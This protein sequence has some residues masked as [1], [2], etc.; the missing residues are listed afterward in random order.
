M[1]TD[2]PASDDVP[3]LVTHL[4]PRN[5]GVTI[6]LGETAAR[7]INALHRSRVEVLL[8]R[9]REIRSILGMAYLHASA[10]LSRIHSILGVPK[11]K[12]GRKVSGRPPKAFDG[13]YQR[14]RRERLK[15]LGRCTICT[16]PNPDKAY[17]NCEGCR[18]KARKRRFI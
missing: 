6:Q 1:N 11:N 18:S 17:V 2:T 8:K 12:R 16:Q 7:E 9:E 10:R 4:D 13:D 5:C 14:L 3:D 15:A